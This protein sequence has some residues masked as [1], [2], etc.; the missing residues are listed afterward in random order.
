MGDWN[1][2]RT[3]LPAVR[4][5]LSALQVPDFATGWIVHNHPGS[6]ST[7]RPCYEAPL[8]RD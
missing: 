7:Q 6:L 8:T 5:I 2:E 3:T 1:T 4:R